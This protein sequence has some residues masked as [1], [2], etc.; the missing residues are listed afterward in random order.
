VIALRNGY[1]GGTSGT[2]GLTSPHTWKFNVPHSFGIQHAQMPDT[3]RGPYG[4]DDP[5][6][7]R[8]YA[9]DVNNLIQFGTSAGSPPLSPNPSR[10]WAGRWCSPMGI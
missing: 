8:K 1:H 9:L 2:M 5:D 3:Y 10:E 4:R 7:G 6:A